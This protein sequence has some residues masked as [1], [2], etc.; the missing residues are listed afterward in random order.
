[1][2]LVALKN[3]GFSFGEGWIFRNLNLEIQQG[4]FIAVIGANGAD[5]KSVV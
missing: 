1:M 4:D 5:R 2:Q 3:L